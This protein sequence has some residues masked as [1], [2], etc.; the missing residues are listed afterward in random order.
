MGANDNAIE[1]FNLDSDGQVVKTWGAFSFVYFSG[2]TSLGHLGL[3]LISNNRQ[4]LCEA[5]DRWGSR[6]RWSN[7]WHSKCKDSNYTSTKLRAA[8]AA[9]A[10]AATAAEVSAAVTL[11]GDA[12]SRGN[13]SQLRGTDEDPGP[14]MCRPYG[15]PTKRPG[16]PELLATP[17]KKRTATNG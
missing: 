7:D 5:I 11:L 17:A 3:G 16:G 15:V 1:R 8:N 4:D 6:C 9:A 2:L 12:R 14:K 10:G 13:I